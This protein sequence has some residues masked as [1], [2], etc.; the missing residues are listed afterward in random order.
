MHLARTF[1]LENDHTFRFTQK[2]NRSRTIFFGMRSRIS[3]SCKEKGE[4]SFVCRPEVMIE[5]I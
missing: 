1:A 5:H 2:K 3:V 4:I